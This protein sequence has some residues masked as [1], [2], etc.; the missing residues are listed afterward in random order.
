MPQ[1]HWQTCL[2]H[3]ERELPAE[4]FNTWIRPLQIKSSRERT[5]LLAPNEYVRDYILL[6]HL[7][8]IRD[9]FEHLGVSR[10]MVVVDVSRQNSVIT[11]EARRPT[12]Q[13]RVSSGLDRRY[14]FKNF[15]Q[16]KSNELAYAASQQVA[17]KPGTSYNPLVIYGSTGLGKTHLLHAAGNLLHKRNPDSKVV[18]LGSEQFVSEM[19]SALRGD[20][21][22][23]FKQHYRTAEA[24][25]IDDVQFFA[26]KER[27]QE[28]FFHT[29]NALLDSQQ[30]IILTC[31][32]Y[33]KEVDGIEARLRSRFGWGLTV[34]IEPPDFETRV[35]I[36]MNKAQERNVFLEEPVAY[37]VARRVRSHVR[38][39]EG[40]LN[41]L[42]ANARF[43]GRPITE[44]FAQEV[45]REL[46]HVH[47][48][49]ITIENIQKAV[50]E[51]YKLRVSDLLSRR[52]PRTIARPRQVAMA[53]CK[54]LTEHSLPEIGDAFGGRDHTTVLHACRKIEELCDT[55][56]RI[57]EDKAKLVRSLTA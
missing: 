50:A 23:A 29:F 45:L 13:K 37:L 51:Y 56:G 39:L 12:Q 15:V 42:F 55:D 17:K 20:R 31:D 54:E 19:I 9:I 44:S 28:E 43:T 18:Y 16:G 35:A 52:R 49:L 3:L 7:E 46:F 53:L 21:I 30:Q 48:R 8:R 38:D 10:D 1:T 34:S 57:R 14:R 33:P 2:N 11:P 24:L 22:E 47:D 40:A 25:L 27:T 32:R 6:N 26:G 4:D 41:T 5:V 36:L